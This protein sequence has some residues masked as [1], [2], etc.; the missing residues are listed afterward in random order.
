M[1]FLVIARNRDA[2]SG[3]NGQQKKAWYK[4]RGR[5]EWRPKSREETPKKGR[6]NRWYSD[7]ALQQYEC[8]PHKMQE[9]KYKF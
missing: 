5:H 6:R 4:K 2:F 8:A 3:K 9:Q 1:I 7:I